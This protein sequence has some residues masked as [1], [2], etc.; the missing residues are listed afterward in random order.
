MRRFRSFVAGSCCPRRRLFLSCQ[1]WGDGLTGGLVES[2]SANAP[3]PPFSGYRKHVD[4][5]FRSV[6]RQTSMTA[7]ATMPLLP[8][9]VQKDGPDML[10]NPMPPWTTRPCVGTPRALFLS[11]ETLN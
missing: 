11:I 8:C 6:F 10:E 9:V 5:V 7:I 1:R 2:G 4:H 3:P